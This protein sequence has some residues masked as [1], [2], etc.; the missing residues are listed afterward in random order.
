MME[1]HH[2]RRG[3][4]WIHIKE[5]KYEGGKRKGE[6]PKKEKREMKRTINV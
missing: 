6:T 3:G 1:M 4:G 2:T 5:E